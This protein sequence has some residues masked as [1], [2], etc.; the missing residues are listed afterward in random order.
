MAKFLP[1]DP[2]DLSSLALIKETLA[3]G[4]LIAYPTDTFYG[5]GA[6]PFNTEAVAK[7]FD[8]K[9]RSAGKPILVLVSSIEQLDLLTDKITSLA[10]TAMD[11]FWPGPLT[12]LFESLPHLP[13]ALTG[14]TG[15]IGVR[16]PSHA[17]T[18]KLIEGIGHP[19]TGSSANLSGGDNPRTAREVELSIGSKLDLI[20]DCGK[21]EGQ[22]VSTV[23]DPTVTPP[24][25]VREGAVTRAK[26][27]SVLNCACT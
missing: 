15:K 27:E 5:L 14:G 10:Q 23:L 3:E 12:L 24:Q 19:L 9:Q 13:E 25:I 2:G 6:D 1:L 22:Q 8:I 4:G 7:I 26:I 20:L 16:F 21:T 17:F 18:Q 11:A